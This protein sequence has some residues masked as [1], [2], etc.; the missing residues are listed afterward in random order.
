MLK[1]GRFA[2]FAFVV[3]AVCGGTLKAQTKRFRAA[4]DIDEPK[5]GKIVKVDA[6]K[7]TITVKSDIGKEHVLNVESNTKLFGTGSKKISGLDDKALHAGA[8]VSWRTDKDGKLKDMH[9]LEGRGVGKRMLDRE[10][11][12]E[13]KTKASTKEKD[14][15]KDTSK[16]KDKEKDKEKEK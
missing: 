5:V 4:E 7:K 9:L 1:L 10:M 2:I 3:I 6:D 11:E 15:S 8:E 13:A 14:K 12:A 16:D